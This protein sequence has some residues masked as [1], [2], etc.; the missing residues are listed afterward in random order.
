MG[1]DSPAGDAHVV[2]PKVFFVN[3]LKVL[4]IFEDCSNAVLTWAR[5]LSLQCPC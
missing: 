1:R 2:V 5:W 4:R 3:L